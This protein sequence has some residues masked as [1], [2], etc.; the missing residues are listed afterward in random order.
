ML[1]RKFLCNVNYLRALIGLCLLVTTHLGQIRDLWDSQVFTIIT[2]VTVTVVVCLFAVIYG[3][4]KFIVHVL[5]GLSLL[6][7]L[8]LFI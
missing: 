6:I 5:I 4:T 3:I 1:V 2:V 7:H 8:F